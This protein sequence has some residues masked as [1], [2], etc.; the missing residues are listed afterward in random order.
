[1]KASRS[2]LSLARMAYRRA[3]APLGKYKLQRML[4]DGLPNSF[5]YPLAFLFDKR[6]SHS[7]QHVV[8]RIELIREA[9]NRQDR[10]FEVVNRDG[11]VCQRTSSQIAHW[12]SVNAEWGTFLY[13]CSRSFTARTIL[14]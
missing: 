10:L 7:E 1:M 12:A 9:V 11:R 13:L 8:C 5:Q 4:G 14:E 6:L 3:M 2:F